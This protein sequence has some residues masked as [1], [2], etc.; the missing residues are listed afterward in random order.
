MHLNKLA[1]ILD[2]TGGIWPEVACPRGICD[3]KGKRFGY[4]SGS[5]AYPGASFLSYNLLVLIKEHVICES[6]YD[7]L[8][9]LI[10]TIGEGP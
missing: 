5:G 6:K 10:P 2:I 7:S 3:E 8:D 4:M 1:I 9:C